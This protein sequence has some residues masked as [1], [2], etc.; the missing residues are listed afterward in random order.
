MPT[1]SFYYGVI[2]GRFVRAGLVL[3]LVQVLLLL[4]AFAVVPLYIMLTVGGVC[5]SQILARNFRVSRESGYVVP[6]VAR[7][8]SELEG[9][10]AQGT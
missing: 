6:P 5:V 3:V 2:R 4:A 1:S 9:T 7:P 10:E 8:R